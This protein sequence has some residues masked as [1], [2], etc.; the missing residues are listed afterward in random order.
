MTVYL[1]MAAGYFELV[2][3]ATGDP[4]GAAVLS[5]ICLIAGIAT[6]ILCRKGVDK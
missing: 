5:G 4:A 6:A 2:F 3:V 1:W